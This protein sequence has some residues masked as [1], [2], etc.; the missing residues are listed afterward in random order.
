MNGT[1]YKPNSHKSRE[2]K[3]QI[4]KVV[5][6]TVKTKKKSKLSG[7]TDMIISED[8]NSV[9][10][11]ILLDVLVPS[12]KKAVCDIVTD[13]IN[14]VLFGGTGSRKSSS[15]RA[16]YVSYDKYSD[17]DR[18]SSSR[19]RSSTQRRY[20][21]DSIILESR[22]EAEEVLTRM[23]EIIEQY[24]AVSVADLFDLVGKT[25]NYTDNDYGWTNLRA[26]DVIRTRD[27]Y[28][29]KLPRVSSIK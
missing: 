3:K 20:S 8:A 25:C 26:A 4:E 22:G 10:S 18:F 17:K 12:I 5:K 9:G 29:L 16:G 24:G 15:T 21:Y 2:E 19:D 13:G 1:D 14:I 27:G 6:G 23:E 28:V 7:F 11:Y